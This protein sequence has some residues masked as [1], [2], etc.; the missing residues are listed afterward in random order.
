METIRKYSAT[1][2]RLKGSRLKT[3]QKIPEEGMKIWK[4]EYMVGWI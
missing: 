4:D 1:V 2:W 3:G